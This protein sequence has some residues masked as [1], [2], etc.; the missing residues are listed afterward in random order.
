MSIHNKSNSPDAS[1]VDP[2]RPFLDT[3]LPGLDIRKS[4]KPKPDANSPDK[5]AGLVRKGGGR[6]LRQVAAASIP[7]KSDGKKNS[8]NS[9]E[10]DLP[11]NGTA[12]I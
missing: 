7:A 10:Y 1:T 6:R 12:M 4:A 11:T 3:P 9:E 2:N 5:A 8:M